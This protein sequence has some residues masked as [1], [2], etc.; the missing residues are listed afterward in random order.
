MKKIILYIA[1]SLDQRIAEPGG[2]LD[3]LTGF[4]NPEKA[5][6]G[7]KELSASVDTV[8]MGGR[9]Y[10]EILNMDVIWPYSEQTAYV[11]SHHEWEAKG[12]IRFITEN[13]IETISELRNQDGKDIWLVGGGKLVSMLL[14]ADLIDEMQICYVPLILGNGILLFPGQDKGSKWKITGTNVYN[15]GML[16]V[17]YQKILQYHLK[18]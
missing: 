7:Y 4:S 17:D 12:N 15:S 5:D 16:K 13:I 11:V 8:I 9:T 1:A 3:W 10:R 2:E 6:Y 14:A 18:Y